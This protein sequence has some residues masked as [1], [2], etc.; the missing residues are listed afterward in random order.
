MFNECIIFYLSSV[1]IS[2]WCGGV[3]KA[4]VSDWRR[5]RFETRSPVVPF[6][7]REI[8]LVIGVYSPLSPATNSPN[9]L[10]CIKKAPRH[11][12]SLRRRS[13][14][15]KVFGVARKKKF[16]SKLMK[17]YLNFNL[18]IYIIMVRHIFFRILS[19]IDG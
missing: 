17:T 7:E 16:I 1:F 14:W 8:S 9:I 15:S 6:A 10:K 18:I 11:P 4:I 5:P 3:G 12:C 13:L 19:N 2:E